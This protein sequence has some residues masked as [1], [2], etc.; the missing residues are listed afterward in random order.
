MIVSKYLHS[1]TTSKIVALCLWA[2]I[3]CFTS[4]IVSKLSSTRRAVMR[5]AFAGKAISFR[6]YL[7]QN[8]RNLILGNEGSNE[9]NSMALSLFPVGLRR[10]LS[11]KL[12]LLLLKVTAYSASKSQAPRLNLKGHNICCVHTGRSSSVQHSISIQVLYWQAHFFLQ[13]LL[14]GRERKWLGG[15][16]LF[17]NKD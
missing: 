6:M 14:L 13:P 7:L 9:R 16:G 2:T 11:S 12:A 17:C 15:A 8:V 1:G 4:N 10:T 3:S 5:C